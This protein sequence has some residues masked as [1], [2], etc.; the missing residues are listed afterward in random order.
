MELSLANRKAITRSQAVRYRRGTKRQKVVILDSVCAVTGYNRDYARRAL[1][2]A[3][4]P[5]YGEAAGTP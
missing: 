1:R 3:L 5:R 2:R 4:I